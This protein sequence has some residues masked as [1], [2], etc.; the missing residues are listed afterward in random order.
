M[1][2]LATLRGHGATRRFESGGHIRSRAGI[3]YPD[4]QYHFLPLAISHDGHTLA[5]GHGF[6]VHVGTKSVSLLIR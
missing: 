3:L 6:Q 5:A 4:I 2:W 1:Q